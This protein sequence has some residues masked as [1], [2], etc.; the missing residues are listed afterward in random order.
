MSELQAGQSPSVTGLA[1]TYPDMRIQSAIRSLWVQVSP[2]DMAGYSPPTDSMDFLEDKSKAFHQALN[3]VIF[4]TNAYGKSLHQNSVTFE[5]DSLW[6][7]NSGDSIY[8][9]YDSILLL[10]N[11]WTQTAPATG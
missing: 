9:D 10:L 8:L 6:P 7:E 11:V 1:P 3:D 5:S 4:V 2:R